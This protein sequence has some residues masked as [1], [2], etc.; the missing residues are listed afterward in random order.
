MPGRTLFIAGNWKMNKTA[1]EAEKTLVELKSKVASI[2]SKIKIAVCPTFTALDRA[3]K[4]IKGSNIKLGAQDVSIYKSGA[5]TGDISVEMLKALN[6]EYVIVGHSERRQY[7][8]ETDK[9]VADKAK[10]VLNGGLFPIVCIGETLEEREAGKMPSVITTQLK[11]SL[12]NISETEIL[13]VTIAYEPVWA[14]GTGKTASPAQAQEVH[15]LIR[16]LLTGKYGEKI[17]EQII[18]QY[19]GSVKPDNAAELMGQKDIDGALVGG[20][21]LEAEAFSVLISKAL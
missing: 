1:D 21:S 20:A 3:S 5:Y 13:K 15:A 19:G 14:I 7:H 10:A 2:G 9:I 6:V 4:V 16:K 11:G 17:A 12:N 8:N 18:I